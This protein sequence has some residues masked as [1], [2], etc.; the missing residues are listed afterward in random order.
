MYTKPKDGGKEPM[1]SMPCTS[2]MSTVRIGEGASYH[3]GTGDPYVDNAHK[4]DKIG[5]HDE[6][7]W[8]KITYFVGL[9]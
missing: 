4:Q 5:E 1:K 2:N 7:E 9:W 6:T 8:A 3:D